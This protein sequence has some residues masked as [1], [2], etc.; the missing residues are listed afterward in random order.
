[1][2]NSYDEHD[3]DY[4]DLSITIGNS[5]AFFFHLALALTAALLGD[6]DKSFDMYWPETTFEPSGVAN[7]VNVEYVGAFPMTILFVTYFAITA[8]SHFGNVCMWNLHYFDYLGA[9]MNPLRWIEYSITA[10][11]MTTILAFIAGTRNILFIIAAATLTFSTISFGFVVD[12]T[13]KTS[14]LLGGLVPF[15][16]E[17]SL[18]ISSLF[19]TTNCYPSYVPITIFVEFGLW[20][21]F[22]LISFMQLKKLIAYKKG[23]LCFIIMSFASKAVLFLVLLI[24]NVLTDGI[25]GTC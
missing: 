12:H 10:P 20:A 24:E 17:F 9:R 13:R 21:I 14:S 6:V 4:I 22:P 7:T 1:M 3:D 11:L 15:V 2:R 18:V 23:E 8:L 16:V 5:L 25:Q 19:V